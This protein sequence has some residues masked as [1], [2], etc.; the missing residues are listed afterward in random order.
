M[1]EPIRIAVV[2]EGPTDFVVI[3][4]AIAS[5]LK[6]QDFEPTM[7][8][9]EFSE[10]F[11]TIGGATGLGWPGVYRWSQQAASE[12]QGHLRNS[13]LFTFHDL[14]VL[15]LDAD[16]A[17]KSYK[18][19]HIIETETDLPCEQPCPPA[20]ATTDALRK[21]V[22]R[23]LGESALPPHFVF[24]TPS[25][26]IE[27]W[28]IAALFPDNKTMAKKG[29]ECH[30]EPEGQFKQLPKK[31]RIEKTRKDYEAKKAELESSWPAVCKKLTEAARFSNDFLAELQAQGCLDAK[32]PSEG[33][34]N[35]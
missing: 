12:G 35:R 9:P 34:S 19:G 3:T 2:V 27:A 17:E 31:Q 23:W 33:N 25:K 18:S 21:V 10:S 7:V 15:Q 5:L 26:S 29:W 22:L 28:V 8:Q 6:G 30:S 24:C 20:S 1:S 32:T 11:E 16:V 4:A 13:I 14:L